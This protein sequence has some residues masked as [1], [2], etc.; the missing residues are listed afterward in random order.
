LADDRVKQVKQANDIVEVV[1]SYLALRPAGQTFKGLCPF[2]DDTRPSFDVDRNRGRYR[3]WSCGKHGDV[4]SFVQEFEKVSF[5]EALELLARRAGIT[6]D[7]SERPEGGENRAELLDVMRWANKQFHD[8]LLDSPLAEDARRYLGERGLQ[9][10]TV[11]RWG[12][13]FAPGSGNWLVGLAQENHV[14]PELLEKVGLIAPRNQGPG[15]YDRFRDRVQFPIRDVR[16]QTVGFGGRILP[17]SP[18]AAGPKYYNSC[19]T[20]LFSKS[21]QLYGLDQARTVAEKAGY[22]AIVEGYTD[23]LMAHQLGIAQVVAT[24]GT[25]LN[26]R[27]VRQLRRFVPRVVLVFDAD[28]GG[29]KGGDRALELFASHDLELAVAQLPPGLDPCDLLVREGAD[30]F[31]RVLESARD[32]LEFKLQQSVHCHD[33]STVEGKLRVVDSVLNIIALAAPLPGAAGTLKLQLMMNR[34]AHRLALKE[35]IVWARLDELRRERRAGHRRQVPEAQDLPP[36][37][38]G[39]AGAAPETPTP[40]RHGSPAAPEEREL[41]EVLLADPDLV[42]SAARA[43]PAAEVRH[44]GLRRLLEG[45]YA[46]HAEGRPA[47]LDLLRGG[48]HH[49]R[50][51]EKALHMQEIGRAYPDRPGCLERVLERFRERRARSVKQEIHNQLH[52]VD[53][54]AQALEL[55]RRLQNRNVELGPDT[56]SRVESGEAGGAPLASPPASPT[57]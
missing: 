38:E 49:P 12:L 52:A 7:P 9:G 28:E 39:A 44:P 43:L 34:I 53:D 15:W 14:P 55:L 27:H 6:L 40:A 4:F 3:C 32:A 48:L 35:E 50:L 33:T 10:D 8:C 24:M 1:G 11:R 46:L 17:G 42:P 29:D 22:L 56:S 19:D 54:H 5:R 31:R 30:P 25:A 45:L 23:V 21:D 2:H 13:G 41:L 20:P 37:P 16:G 51:E 47:T 26:E 18:L 36:A 57:A